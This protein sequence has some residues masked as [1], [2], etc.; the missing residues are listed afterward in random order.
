MVCVSNPYHDITLY[1]IIA[2]KIE[3]YEQKSILL[4]PTNFQLHATYNALLQ[5]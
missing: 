1:T 5:T 3:N 2:V 4:I